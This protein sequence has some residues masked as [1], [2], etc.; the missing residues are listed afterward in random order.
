MNPWLVLLALTVLAALFVVVPVAAV[1]LSYWRRPRQV[2]CPRA[3]LE[4][5]IFVDAGRATL[6]E[7]LGRPDLTVSRCSL[8][9][10]L[11]R[12]RFCRQDCL[13]QTE[14]VP[15]EERRAS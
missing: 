7:V 4:A 3:G 5:R 6:G 9:Q 2:R 13:V 11:P 1:S 8:W 10:M 12:L 15:S 14:P